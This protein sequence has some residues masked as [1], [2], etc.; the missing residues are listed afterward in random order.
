MELKGLYSL[1]WIR[2]GRQDCAAGLCKG[3]PWYTGVKLTLHSL[4]KHNQ[5]K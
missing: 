1:I 5:D 3:L 2:F 4:R